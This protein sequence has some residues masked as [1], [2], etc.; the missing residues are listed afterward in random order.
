VPRPARLILN[1]VAGADE[2]LD[3][4]ASI[5][6]RLRA[7][8]GDL[9]IVITTG[10]GDAEASAAR[11]AREGVSRL[12]VAGGDGTLNEVLNGIHAEG[13]LDRTTFG[14]LPLG[15][16]NDFA[17]ALGIP[18][19]VDAALE[20]LAGGREVVV[21]VG[22]LNDRAFV[23]VSAGGFIGEVSDAVTPGLKTVAGKMAYLIGGAQVLLS[24][25]PVRTRVNPLGDCMVLS[26]GA[27]LDPGAGPA[28]ADHLAARDAE[29]Y[30]FAVC[31][32]RLVGGGRLIAPLA[33]ADDGWLDVCVI[34][35]MPT[36]DFVGLLRAVAAGDHVSDARVAYLRVRELTLD[37]DRAIKVNTDG[38]VL[39]TTRCHY[40]V[41]PGATRF[42]AGDA[43]VLG[44][45][46][47]GMRKAELSP[48]PEHGVRK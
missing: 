46:E 7:G 2:G 24:Y 42:L 32:S 39:E 27:S 33:V 44:S 10:P 25:E 16:G 1:P 20:T 11:A 14:I 29:V 38:Q 6:A 23:N 31:N 43:W 9:D 15:T 41:I 22:L 36:I 47:G 4:I 19:E 3:V 28:D 48:N 45:A 8:C 35:A 13:A 34:E 18:N 12:F 17:G 37:F 5:N 30:L 40:R 26:P 21:D